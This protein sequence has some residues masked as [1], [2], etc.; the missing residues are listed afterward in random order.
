MNPLVQEVA[1]AAAKREAANR[2]YKRAMWA[3]LV[4]AEIPPRYIA[5]ATGID[6]RVIST[7]KGRLKKAGKPA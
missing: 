1:R 3:A 5:E 4:D 2:E 7:L 6:R